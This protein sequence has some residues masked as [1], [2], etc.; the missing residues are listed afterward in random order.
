MARCGK[1]GEELGLEW[2]GRWTSP[3]DKPHLQLKTGRTLVQARQCV[4]DGEPVA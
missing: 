1:I 4:R 3:Q 2:G